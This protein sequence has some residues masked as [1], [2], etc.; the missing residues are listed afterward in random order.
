[1]F[2]QVVRTPKQTTC[3]QVEALLDFSLAEFCS[4]I[5][6]LQAAK[7]TSNTNL[8]GGFIR[9]AL[10]EYRHAYLFSSLAKNIAWRC[11][12]VQTNLNTFR[13]EQI[14]LANSSTAVIMP[15]RHSTRRP[16]GALQDLPAEL[17]L[18]L[19]MNI[20]RRLERHWNKIN[21]L[22]LNAE[23]RPSSGF[24]RIVRK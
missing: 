20:R 12:V 6:M 13:R 5:E 1:M 3:M 23:F 11:G 16:T 8:A 17:G 10:D 24:F 4:G 19:D 9:H 15:R 2:K 14:K 22:D 18:T 7:R 21:F